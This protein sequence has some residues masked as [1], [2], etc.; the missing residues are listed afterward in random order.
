MVPT[1]PASSQDTPGKVRRNLRRFRFVVLLPILFGLAGVVY[2]NQVGLPGFLKRPLVRQLHARGLKLEFDRLRLLWGRG[3]VAEQVVLAEA[4]DGEG[5]QIKF[6]EVILDP[7]WPKLARLEFQLDSIKLRNGLLVVPLAMTDPADPLFS[8]D[9]VQAELRFLPDDRWELTRLTAKGL[10]VHLQA[11]G[12]L[13]HASAVHNWSRGAVPRDREAALAAWQTHL[14]RATAYAKRWRF[15]R[16]PVLTLFISGDARS[17]AGI[18]ADLELDARAIESPWGSLERLSVRGKLNR[19]TETPG[20]GRSDVVGEFQRAHTAWGGI[21]EGQWELRWIQAFTNPLPTEVRWRLGAEQVESPWGETPRVELELDAFQRPELPG[22]LIGEMSFTSDSILG[23]LAH[24]ETNRLTTRVRLDPVTYLPSIVDYQFTAANARFEGGTARAIDIHGTMRVREGSTREAIGT[25]WGGWAALE[26][27]DLSCDGRIDGLELRGVIF[28]SV[29]FDADWQVPELRL[30]RLR[31]HREGE[32]LDAVGSVN[33]ETRNAEATASMNLD[34]HSLSPLLTPKSVRWLGQYGWERPPRVDA[35]VRLV[36]PGWTDAQ[37]D[38]KGEVLPTLQLDGHVVAAHASYRGVQAET[39]ELHFTHSNRVW[40]LPELVATRPE[41]QL[42][43][44]YTEDT[45]TRDYHFRVRSQIDP[46]ALRP[47]LDTKAQKAFEL[48]HFTTPPWVAGDVRG[49]WRDPD[50]TSVQ[51][52]LRTSEFVFREE[53]IDEL[54]ATL[55]FT[56]RFLSATDVQVRTGD[57][58]VTAPGVG[59]RLDD[60]VLFLTNASAHIDPLRVARAIGPKTARILSPYH[61]LEPPRA[62]VDGSVNVSKPQSAELRFEV[63]GGPFHYWRFRLPEVEATVGWT[64]DTVMIHDLEAPFYQGRLAG[65]FQVDVGPGEKTPFE[66]EARVTR[67]DFHELLSDLHSPTNRIEGKLSVELTVSRADAGDW[68]SWQGFGKAELLDGF[69]WDIPMF[70]ILSPLLNA[71]LP[72]VGKSRVTDADTTFTMTNSVIH[73]KDLELRA[74]LFRLAYRGTVDF[75][76]RVNARVEAQLL[77]DAWLIGPLV[78]LV[79]SPLAKILEYQ[80]S[81]TLG[82][83]RLELIHIPKPFQAPFNPLRTLREMFEEK[84]SQIPPPAP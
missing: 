16:P 10:G 84:P 11:S 25:D 47:L 50:R 68:Q 66:F 21:R 69:L 9:G 67:A 53:P 41:G 40:H 35:S 74:P 77:R 49:R 5:P 58:S 3:L 55:Q 13:T 15:G 32:W 63:V 1:V 36:L 12:L 19:A 37:P 31:I 52:E 82:Q 30:S 57:G 23:G 8:I 24:A 20:L 64:N 17:P 29:D 54:R 44:S 72:G 73:M 39:V 4:G 76:G 51:A 33:V 18:T 71:V 45:S 83:P 75:D 7:D 22:Q 78:S 56:N 81:G 43:F 70:G 38:W 34:V 65:R 60:Q 2:L 26:P 14:H 48:F 28:D 46:E 59:L 62:V 61:F 79:F 27:F 80:I 6:D 42:A